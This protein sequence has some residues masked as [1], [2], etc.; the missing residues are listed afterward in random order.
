M[1]RLM[2]VGM[3]IAALG[4]VRADVIDWPADFAEQVAASHPAPSGAQIAAS[5]E[6]LSVDARVSASV[7]ELTTI[8][9][10]EGRSTSTELSNEA[11]IDARRPSGFLFIVR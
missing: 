11:Q 10:I 4:W 8:T 5:A 6:A 3:V 9:E 2:M 7:E 1:K